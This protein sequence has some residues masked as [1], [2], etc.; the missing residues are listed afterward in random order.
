ML[1]PPAHH[2]FTKGKEQAMARTYK[3]ATFQPTVRPD[4]GG[5]LSYLP[6]SEKAEILE[7][8]IKYPSKDCDSAF[9][10]ETIKPDLDFQY[11]TFVGACKKKS[12]G[13]RDR[14]GKISTTYLQHMNNISTTDVQDMNKIS[15]TYVIDVEEKDKNKDKDED[16][17]KSKVDIYTRFNAGFQNWKF[18]PVLLT[19]A[20]KYWTADTIRKIEIDF[21]C[22]EYNT[23]TSIQELLER[24]PA[25]KDKAVLPK[26]LGQYEYMRPQMQKWIDY[27]KSRG[28]KYKTEQS[29]MVCA[30]KLHELSGGNALNA[31]AIVEQSIA[32]N[33]AGL[34]PLKQNASPNMP[35]MSLKEMKQLENDIKLQKLLNG[36]IQ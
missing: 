19:V 6:E 35:R 14:W 36:E 18:E 17:V 20:K 7:A 24:Y 34:F 22:Q 23:E 27:K 4:W 29:L 12:Q 33:Y 1:V 3:P 16:K 15:D 26:D 8:I 9:W 13:I 2:L 10:L 30:K 25:D 5:A 28:E 11:E 21:S 31:D 32:S